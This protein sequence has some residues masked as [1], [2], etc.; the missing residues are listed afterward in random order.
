MSATKTNRRWGVLMNTE[1]SYGAGGVLA[2][3][4]HGFRVHEDPEP[5]VEYDFDGRRAG[6]APATAGMN[7]NVP[8][9]SRFSRVSL[10][11]EVHGAG[12]AY[13]AAVKPSLH[14]ALLMAGLSATLV[15]GVSYSYAPTADDETYSSAALEIYRRGQKYALN[16]AYGDG[17]TLA[18]EAG[19]PSMLT[20]PLVGRMPELPTD[21]ALPAITYPNVLPPKALAM[22]VSIGGVAQARVR[23][24]SLE[25]T[26]TVSPRL[27]DASTGVHGGFTPNADREARLTLV[28]E[29]LALATLNPFNL[30]DL[31]TQ[32][33]FTLTVGSANFNKYT[34]SGA[35]GQIEAVSEGAEGPVATWELE[36]ALKASGPAANDEFALLFD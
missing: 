26:R 11:H 30:R 21:A 4:S 22:A 31:M 34:L 13:A 12:A 7:P 14:T 5:S 6:K 20:L 16:G 15:D 8:P 18:A 33:A 29:A 2:G 1:A 19:R 9:S 24:F 23:S 36:V 25:F 28:C 17:F 3:A 10:A 27:F 32:V 35:A